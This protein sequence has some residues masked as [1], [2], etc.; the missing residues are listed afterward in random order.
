M[1]NRTIKKQIVCESRVIHAAH[2]HVRV[3]MY[4]S[5]NNIPMYQKKRKPTVVVAVASINDS[6]PD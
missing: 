1:N 2:T 6:C 3:F 5:N 4:V